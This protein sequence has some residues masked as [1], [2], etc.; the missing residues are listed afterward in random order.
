[1]R[2]CEADARGRVEPVFVAEVDRQPVDA[3]QLADTGHGRFE[4]MGKRQLRDRLADD[5]E[6][7]AR[8]L[9][10]CGDGVCVDARTQRMCGAN[11]ERRQP[12]ELVFRRSST[13][14]EEELQDADRRLPELQGG[15]ELGAA[16]QLAGDGLHAHCQPPV[17]RAFGGIVGIRDRRVDC[18]DPGRGDELERTALL[19]APE[20]TRQRAGRLHR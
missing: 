7:G 10:L 6:Q 2:T 16:R 14:G 9:E 19:P 8:P 13:R 4:R 20:Q 3:Q 18:R 1:M 12:R 17:Q 15:G 5:R 11:A